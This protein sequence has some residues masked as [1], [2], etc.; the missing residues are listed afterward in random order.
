M[1]IRY[2][3]LIGRIEGLKKRVAYLKKNSQYF[4]IISINLNSEKV[5][6]F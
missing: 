5:Q 4:N 3:T 1:S 6:Q 2:Y